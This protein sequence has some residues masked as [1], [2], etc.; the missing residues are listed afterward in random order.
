L[1]VEVVPAGFSALLDC[2]LRTDFAVPGSRPRALVSSCDPVGRITCPENNPMEAE[3]HSGRP[4]CGDRGPEENLVA[5][6]VEP[7]DEVSGGAL[8]R[9]LIEEGLT[10]FPKR[11]ALR[12]Q[13]EGRN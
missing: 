6:A 3:H 1:P 10:E 9:L 7:A 12:E 8:A 4:S 11:N 13:V 2:A 5:E